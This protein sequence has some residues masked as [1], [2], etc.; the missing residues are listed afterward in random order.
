MDCFEE[1]VIGDAVSIFVQFCSERITVI[2][3]A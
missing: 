2:T 1:S 3:D